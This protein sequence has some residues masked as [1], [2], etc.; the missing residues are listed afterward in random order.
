MARPRPVHCGQWRA[1]SHLF[2]V[3]GQVDMGRRSRFA[4]RPDA[5]HQRVQHRLA[6]RVFVAR[7]ERAQ[8]DGNT[9]VFG[10]CARLA[11]ASSYEINSITI[12]L[13]IAQRVLV[14]AGTLA[15]HVVA[16]AH[17]GF[18]A[19]GIG[20]LHRL[21]HGLAQHELAAQELHGTQGGRHHRARTQ[22]GHETR[23]V[24]RIGQKV[25]G[26][27]NGRTGQAREHLVAAGLEVSAAQLVGGQRDGGLGIRH[28]QQGFGQAHQGQTFGAGDGVFLEQAFHGPEGRRV[29]AHGLH[30]RFGGAG[31][32]GPVQGAVQLL[33]TLRNDFALRAVGGGQTGGDGLEHTHSMKCETCAYF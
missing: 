24:L 5:G 13:Q 28:P 4:Q 10:Q 6:V 18:F 8:L 30:P 11:C 31:G 29:L 16:E 3:N 33:Q 17:I 27:R 20:L 19:C 7:V 25:F 12:T 9:I 14:G 22:L 15:Q 23:L 21:G 26:Q 32:M 1:T 2:R